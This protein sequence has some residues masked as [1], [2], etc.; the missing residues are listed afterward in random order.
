MLHRQQSPRGK[1]QRIPGQHS[2]HAEAADVLQ[3][4]IGGAT[5]ADHRP[6]KSEFALIMWMVSPPRQHTNA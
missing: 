3:I 1:H 2:G 4:D 6:A 5:R